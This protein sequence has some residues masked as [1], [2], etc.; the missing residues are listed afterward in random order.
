[1]PSFPV[2]TAVQHDCRKKLH[3]ST[4]TQVVY[5]LGTPSQDIPVSDYSYWW[6]EFVHKSPTLLVDFAF[7]SLFVNGMPDM[8][9]LLY[10]LKSFNC[11]V[12]VN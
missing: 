4:L 2:L 5:L 10:L 9:E 7:L 6:E 1:M 8:K 3:L 12:V 11:K